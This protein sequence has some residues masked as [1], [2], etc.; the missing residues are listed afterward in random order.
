MK[1]NILMNIARILSSSLLMITCSWQVAA[2]SAIDVRSDAQQAAES[3]VRSLTEAPEHGELS[4]TA[5]PLDSRLRL[6]ACSAPLLAELAGR[7][8]IGSQVTVRVAC[9]EPDGWN[10]YVPVRVKTLRPVVV[11]KHAIPGG[12]ILEK[13]MVRVVLKD[14][15]LVHR[16]VFSSD[17]GIIGSRIKRHLQAGQPITARNLCLVC[18]GEPVTIIAESKNLKLKTDGIAL[19]DGGN[20]ETVSIR[21]NRSKRVIEA[22]VVSV[23]LVKISF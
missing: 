23:G 13:S 6:S 4:V 21:N 8:T 19:S 22:N 17:E 10:I 5:A 7:G 1:R 11:A 20:G 12:S 14:T 2:D 18:K 15:K 16:Q 3:L 9:P